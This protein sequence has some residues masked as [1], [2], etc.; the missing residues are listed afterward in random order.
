M[1]DDEGIV[2]RALGL[3]RVADRLRSTAEFRQRVKE[4]VR[5]IEAMNLKVKIGT[6]CRVEHPLQTLDVGCL[7]DRVDEALIP[8]PGGTGRLSHMRPPKLRSCHATGST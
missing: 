7:L 8:K 4:M 1:A 3:E 2:S 6:S 5:R